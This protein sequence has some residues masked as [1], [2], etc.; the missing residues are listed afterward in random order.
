L[1]PKDGILKKVPN[2]LTVALAIPTYNREDVLVNT[3]KSALSLQPAP[4]E[5]LV[6]DQTAEHDETTKRFL[7]DSHRKGAIRWIHHQ[8]PSL[9]AARNKAIADT[10]SDILIFV[11]DDV[12]LPK[13]FIAN[14]L[15]NYKNEKVQAVAGGVNQENKPTYPQPP[16]GGKWPR[17][18][19]YKYFSVFSQKRTEGVATF[20]GCNHSVRTEVLRRLGGYDTSYIGSAF[21]EDT[22][23]AVR[24]WINGGLIVFDPQARLTHLAT[25]SGGCRINDQPQSNPEWWV[26]FNRHY[27]SFR[28][29]FPLGEFWRLIFIQ[30]FRQTVLRKANVFHPW[31]IPW[32]FLSYGYSVIKAGRMALEK[33]MKKL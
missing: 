3:V 27:F 21:R 29:L 32:A 2:K 1:T 15:K 12:E 31:R 25:P 7:N 23:M 10:R 14:H 16:V 19:D 24:I 30:D 5:I 28:H 6:V 17:I 20:M 22:D 8:P 18:L 11:D 33:N 9:T 4:D 26:S 13:N